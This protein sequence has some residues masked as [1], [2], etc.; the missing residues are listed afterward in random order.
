MADEQ[1]LPGLDIV[2]ALAI[3]L[4]VAHGAL[5]AAPAISFS[6]R[7]QLLYLGGYTGVELFFALSGFLIVG[8]L[9]RQLDWPY[10]KQSYVESNYIVRVIKSRYGSARK[11][12]SGSVEFASW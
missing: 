8:G 7:S 12:L 10:A 4:V 2:R 1:R 9:L 6:L 11:A 3:T 5:L